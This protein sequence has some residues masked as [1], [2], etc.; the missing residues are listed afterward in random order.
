MGVGGHGHHPA[1]DIRQQQVGQREVPEMVGA[2]LH[3]EPVDGPPLG[4]RHHPGVVDEDIEVAVP[5]RGEGAHGRE[6]GEVE[7][8]D[9][10][11]P[12]DRRRRGLAALLVAHG[13][14]DVGA[15]PRQ[16]PC[17]DEP[18]AAVGPGDDDRVAVEVGQVG[19]GPAVAHDERICA[20]VVAIGR[21]R[22]GMATGL[23]SGSRDHAGAG[24]AA[25]RVSS[26]RRTL[27]SAVR[28]IARTSTSRR[29]AQ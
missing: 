23:R 29:G 17:G 10:G 1:G 6:V 18:D 24:G 4:D 11:R 16:L 19:G 20:C 25:A 9:L 28:G 7:P 15:H 13:E 27:P 21:A 3:L 22:A 2:Q 26:P 5:L 8:E 12:G 14:H